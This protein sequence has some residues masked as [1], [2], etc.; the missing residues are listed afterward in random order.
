[1]GDCELWLRLKNGD[2]Q[3]KMVRSK[4][5][6]VDPC[7]DLLRGIEELIGPRSTRLT[8]KVQAP[9]GVHHSS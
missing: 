6:R 5:I 3:D 2:E 4:T 8:P 9:V 1:M 7:D